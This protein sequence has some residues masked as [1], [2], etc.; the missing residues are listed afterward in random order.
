M[1]RPYDGYMT[2][3]ID[4]GPSFS[5]A[6]V[7]SGLS[8]EIASLAGINVSSEGEINDTL[9]RC[10]H[11]S[12]V[13]S[14]ILSI[15]PAVALV[16]VKVTDRRGVLRD[17][18]ALAA[19][20]DWIL[21]HHARLAIGVVSVALGDQRNLVS[22]VEF[23]GSELQLRIAALREVGVLTAAP[24]G[25]WR[26][27]HRGRGDGMVWPGILREAIS[28]GEAR[29]GPEGLRLNPASQRLRAAPDGPCATTIFTEAAPPGETSGAAAAFAG[30][31]ARL[32]AAGH[33]GGAEGALAALLRLRRDALDEEG[34]AWPA[35]LLEDLSVG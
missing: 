4:E 20:L 1:A 9:D 10:G 11:G 2:I 31:L 16:P 35:V 19:A 32:A 28:V 5:V 6:V 34:R 21:N 15:A 3:E 26:R 30:M 17:R 33:P 18:A 12:A 8:R 14:T 13:A 29:Q 22:D 23:R 27:L 25:N 24:A 7:D